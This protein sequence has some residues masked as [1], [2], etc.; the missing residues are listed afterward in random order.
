MSLI[1]LTLH[2]LLPAESSRAPQRRDRQ[3][4]RLV[5]C[6]ADQRIR[7][8][9][10]ARIRKVDDDAG[11][12]HVG[13]QVREHLSRFRQEHVADPKAHAI[14]DLHWRSWLHVRWLAPKRSGN[15]RSIELTE[16]S[17]SGRLAGRM[18]Y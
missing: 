10:R 17:I 2:P 6:D 13:S 3:Q 15:S 9:A 11:R 7:T 8:R 18:F 12:L 14:A 5:R 16:G 1:G 4:H